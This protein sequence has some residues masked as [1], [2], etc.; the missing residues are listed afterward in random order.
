MQNNTNPPKKQRLSIHDFPPGTYLSADEV[1]EIWG[2][3]VR[4]V[5]R[6]KDAIGYET[7]GGIIRFRQDD[8]LR[9]PQRADAPPKPRTYTKRKTLAEKICNEA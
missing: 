2:I 3:S 1:A 4:W 8:I 6:N 7:I 5:Y 9:F